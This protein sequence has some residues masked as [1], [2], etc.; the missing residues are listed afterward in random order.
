[1]NARLTSVAVLLFLA[2]SLGACQAPQTL[3]PAPPSASAPATPAVDRTPNWVG[4]P[5][6]WSKLV[7]IESWLATRE[8]TADP[9]WKIEGELTLNQGR[10]EL[11]RTEES[12]QKATENAARARLFTSR[13]GLQRVI[14]GTEATADQKKR[15]ETAL[16]QCNKLL[17]VQAAQPKLGLAVIPRARWGAMPAN[18]SHMD[19]TRGGYKR[20]TVHHSA[21]REP[22]NLDGS[23]SSSAAEVRSIQKAHM[24]GKETGY[25]D[26][27]YHFV[28]DPYGRVFQGRDLTFQGAHAAGA[29]NIQNIGVCLIGNF[30]EETP[31]KAAL[32]A[33]RK[34]LDEERAQWKI[35]RSQVFTHQELKSTECPGRNLAS[36]VQAYRRAAGAAAA[37][38]EATAKLG[39]TPREASTRAN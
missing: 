34:L 20:I 25:A 23:V 37:P 3:P 11:A 39:A 21:D 38:V 1:M 13:A 36:W 32:D 33:L 19:K 8:P 28:I 31:T 22:P 10:M 35:P 15:A 26:I 30:D 7:D 14:A 17:G 27:G 5:L 29:N 9:F 24:E 6:S 16:A 4:E 18:V 2:A 12:G